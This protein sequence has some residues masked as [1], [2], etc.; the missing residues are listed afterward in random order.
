MTPLN[1]ILNMLNADKC[2]LQ[3][4]ISIRIPFSDM[5]EIFEFSEENFILNN[6]YLFHFFFA[7]SLSTVIIFLKIFIAN[8]FRNT[9]F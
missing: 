6:F 7:S 1:P 4:T 5:D 9:I 2:N 8:N 3:T